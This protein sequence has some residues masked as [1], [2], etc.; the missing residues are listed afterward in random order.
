MKYS[1]YA[2]KVNN[3]KEEIET[4]WLKLGT[5]LSLLSTGDMLNDLSESEYFDDY[6][7]AILPDIGVGDSVFN[8]KTNTQG[9]VILINSP[10]TNIEFV[11]IELENQDI[12]TWSIKDLI[13][14]G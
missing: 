12:V 10:E 4:M 6:I 3:I 2:K 11:T 9:R 1:L 14:M 7:Y 5:N 8:M 13:V